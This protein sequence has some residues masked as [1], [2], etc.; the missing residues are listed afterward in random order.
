MDA[1]HSRWLDTHMKYLTEDCGA[2]AGDKAI[3]ILLPWFA[4]R[5]R[6]NFEH[7]VQRSLEKKDYELF[8]PTYPEQRRWSDRTKQIDVPLFPGYVFCRMDQQNRMPVLTTPGVVQL[9]GYGKHPEPVTEEE[10]DSIK[11]VLN[12]DLPYAPSP[13]LVPGT[14]VVVDNG[15][16]MGVQGL[17]AETRDGQRLLISINILQRAVAVEIDSRWVRPLK[18]PAFH[19][20][21]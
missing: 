13:S 1:P 20:Q 9:V 10:I 18:P 3:G 21:G 17:L 8:L 16:L 5:V 6:S 15:P 2:R 12:S 14:P 19:R 11:A 4:I 7:S